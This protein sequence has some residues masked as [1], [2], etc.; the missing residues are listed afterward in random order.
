MELSE[1]EDKMVVLREGILEHVSRLQGDVGVCFK[2]QA[3][4]EPELSQA[5]KRRI[6]AELLAESLPRF[7][8]KFH[9]VLLEEHAPYFRAM[10]QSSLS[11]DESYEINFYLEQLHQRLNSNRP[12]VR[13][14]GITRWFHKLWKKGI[15]R[16]FH[17]LWKKGITRWFHKE[18]VKP[19]SDTLLP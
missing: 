19:P 4:G 8:A 5:E 6:A 16:W 17:K 3:R 15:T 1:E 7:L 18:F 2:L 9:T 11:E 12:Q 13:K 10:A 14:K